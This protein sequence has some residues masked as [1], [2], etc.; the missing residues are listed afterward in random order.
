[1]NSATEK[2]PKTRLTTLVD[3]DLV[4]L[5]DKDIIKSIEDGERCTRSSRIN[6][7]LRLHYQGQ[8]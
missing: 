1:M 8:F 4:Q 7:I 2:I 5:L 3:H 6:Q